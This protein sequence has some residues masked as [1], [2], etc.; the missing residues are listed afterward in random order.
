MSNVQSMIKKTLKVIL[1]VMLSFV[2]IFI[3]VA[4]LIQIPSIQTKIVHY[5]TSFVSKKT[6]T[7]VEI[8]NVSISFPKSIVIEGLFLE[9]LKKDTLIYAGRTKINIALYDLLK[10]QIM[11]SS[12]ALNDVNLNLHN[13]ET[14]SL[15]NYNFLLTAFIDTTV[16]AK[17]DTVNASKWTFSIEDVDMENIRLRY[18]DDFGGMNVK[19]SL[20]NM[21]L[22]IDELDLETSI[23]RIDELLVE[24]LNAN[25]LMKGSSKT[26]KQESQSGALMP[27]ITANN[28]EI[29]HSRVSYADSISKQSVLA[30]INQFELKDGSVDL[31]NEIVT[32]DQ[33]NLSGSKIQYLAS[34][35]DTIPDS[36]VVQNV[37]PTESNWKVSA[38]RVMLEDDSVAY[39]VGNKPVI[40]NAF[41]ADHLEF[42]KL[43]L[44]ARD[45]SYSSE[46]TKVSVKKFSAIDQNGFAI[47]SFETDFNMDEHSITAK[48]L[49]ANTTNSNID[50]DFSL[51]YSSM[52]ALTDS[53][54]FKNLNADLR[55]VKISNSDIL[56]FSP[57]LIKQPYFKNRNTNTTVNGKVNGPMNNLKGENMVV[58]AGG[59]TT[60]NTDFIIRGLPEVNTAWYNFPNLS[61]VSDKKD[62]VMIAGPYIPDSMAVPENV[63]M[64]LVFK[65]K[66]KSFESTVNLSSSFGDANLIASV[67]P[68]EN[69][70]TKLSIDNFDVGSLMKDTILYGPVSLT[71]EADG[72][73]LDMATIKAKI[74]AEVTEV[75]LNKYTY[76]NL[77]MEGSVSGKQFEGTINLDDENAVFNFDGLVN[78]NPN[79]EQYK[80]KLN[81]QGADL[82]KL[83]LADGDIQL[84]FITTAD[85]KGGAIDKMNG[86]AGITNIIV[87]RDGKKYQLD[88]LLAASVNEPNKSEINVTSALI[89]IKYIGTLSPIALPAL[90]NQ[91]I[92]NY[93]PVSDSIQQ[94]KNSER[95]DFNFEIQF[96]NHPIL[97]KVLLPELKE[98]EP[99]VIKGSFDSEKNDL[100]LTAEMKRIVYGTTEINDLAVDVNTDSTALNY[101]ISSKSILNSAVILDNFSLDGKLANNTIFA[102][103]S[104]TDGRNKKLLIRSEI[105]KN[106]GN[107]KITLDPKEFY[108]VNNQW[109]IAEDN[110]IE[111]GKEGFKIHHFFINHKASQIN[112]ASVNDRFNDDLNI[113]IKN[114]RLEN[115][116]QIIEKDSSLVQ[117]NLDGEILLK[118]VA[119]SYG[120]ISDIKV[121]NLIVREVP[122]GNITLKA[123]NPTTER[124]D[125]DLNLSGPSN[126]LTTKGYFIPNESVNSLNIKT[127]IQSLSM[128]TVEAFSM[129]QITEA[130]GTLTGNFLIEGK[131]D[132]PDIT[133]EIV[134][135]NVFVKPAFLNNRLGIKNETIELKTDGIYF[136]SFTMEDVAKHEAVI[137]GS[138]K[139]KQF[140]DYVFALEVNTKDFLLFNTNAKDNKNFFGRMVIDSKINVGGSM[141]LPV[142]NAKVKMKEGSNFTFSVPESTL[143]TDKGENVVEFLNPTQL[144][145]ILI[146]GAKNGAQSS[147]MSGFDL[148]S[149][150]EIDK[151]ATLRLLMDPASADSLVVKGEAAL[152]FTM[153]QSGKMSLTGAYNLSD[154]SYLVSLES[155]IKKQ[156]NIQE[157]STI[158]WNGDPMDA[159]IS[160]DATYS[161]R[162]SPSD[163]MLDQISDLTE[164]EQGG[165]KQR[166]P[167]L[168]LL[169][170]RGEILHPQISFEIQL[171]PENKGI[172]GG[173]VNQK[174]IMLNE[175]ESALNKQ[176]FALLVLGRFVQENPF[177]T[178]A[179]GGTSTLIRSTVSKFL[180]AQLN[181]LGAK[182]L[183]GMEL[184]FDIQSYDDYQTG[185]AEG[186]TQVGI[187]AKQQLFNERLSVEIGGSVDVEGNKAKQNSASN[188]TG[189]VTV[190]YKLTK[191][192]RLRMKGFRHN[193]YAGAIEGQLVETGVGVVYVRDFNR[194][195]RLFKSKR[196]RS[197][198][199]KKQDSDDT[200]DAK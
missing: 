165:Y 199:L 48:E 56:Y 22:Q 196:N 115:I 193:Q 145:P 163:L 109:T 187:G 64:K 33:L 169:K 126:N 170:L 123:V 127:I 161:V 188:I 26:N 62:I 122:I 90:L 142:V 135:N 54:Q 78:M 139:M 21:E 124:F 129:G 184:N 192:G 91:F 39:K 189:D 96:H 198:S 51:Q 172:L 20:K 4:F 7:K 31:Q 120:L 173:A 15:F 180:S 117:G 18:D 8:K 160:I 156:F 10:S 14:D 200:N 83:H 49:K 45:L 19:A 110:F 67:D 130:D 80:F 101:K 146:R 179:S 63:S 125:I 41:N 57:D 89:G 25:V 134:F 186:R 183:P 143:T 52:A 113:D 1:W 11:I 66:I 69:F 94:P 116:S 176:V 158:I 61:I 47:T 3:L 93:F 42:T 194:W 102:N 43:T 46:Q 119:E 153:D 144:N 138:V 34:A 95:S 128:K 75:Y 174:L 103:V 71:A 88:S 137:D 28:I 5:A 150:I 167:F 36:T 168:V 111:F 12:F 147:G 178:A 136:D 164:S 157:G 181:Q 133:G 106:K 87:A 68:A 131:T 60:L 59:N 73:G 159:A 58:H 81:V 149:I 148:T 44:D 40:K 182:V 92:N 35:S 24:N 98:F 195:S 171:A 82:K 13:T 38:K 107:Y 65:G 190:E 53:M 151:N 6:H 72:H 99:G 37:T 70:S 30:I 100:K 2:L 55:N 197:D 108:L 97:S 85:M 185:Q 32:L 74:K 86:T 114:F 141:N 84:S 154:G 166:Y 17:P 152:S 162:A 112:I 104:S 16:Q 9:D 79:Q 132:A 121:N 175:D 77:D 118:R 155:V 105:T 140:S 177:Q 23:Y 76:H 50:A 27:K 191:D 29:N